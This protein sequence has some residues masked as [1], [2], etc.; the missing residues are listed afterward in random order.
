METRPVIAAA[1]VEY[2]T[3]VCMALKCYADDADF[4]RE[5]D[6]RLV[7]IPAGEREHFAAIVRDDWRMDDI[8]KQCIDQATLIDRYGWLLGRLQ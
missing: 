7:E 1:T 2:L 6:K 8:L 4:Q 3:T 5:A